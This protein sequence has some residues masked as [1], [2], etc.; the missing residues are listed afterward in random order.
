[1]LLKLQDTEWPGYSKRE[2]INR[3][4]AAETTDLRDGQATADE[5]PLIDRRRSLLR[6]EL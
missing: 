5:R 4:R 3:R 1:M 6:E 2:I